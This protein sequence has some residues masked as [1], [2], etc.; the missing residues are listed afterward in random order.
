MAGMV[1]HDSDHFLVYM[2][3]NKCVER[4]LGT[5][6]HEAKNTPGEFQFEGLMVW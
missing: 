3:K 6:W 2:E 1:V 5:L 4:K